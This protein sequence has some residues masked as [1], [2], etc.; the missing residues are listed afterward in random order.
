MLTNR[1]R[2]GAVLAGVVLALATLAG[3][4]RAA[5]AL[6]VTAK[7][8]R[9]YQERVTKRALMT[10]EIIT[11]ERHPKLAD[12]VFITL[13]GEVYEAR[14][15]DFRT[16]LEQEGDFERLKVATEG[17]LKSLGLDL[18]R[19]AERSEHLMTAIH[20]AQRDAALSYRL[21]VI[22]VDPAPP[23]GTTPK[24]P[25]TT[26]GTGTDP[27]TQVQY[28]YQPLL[29]NSRQNRLQRDWEDDLGKAAA[30][31]Q[32]IQARRAELLLALARQEASLE[33]VRARF[34][35]YAADPAGYLYEPYLVVEREAAL[36][37]DR[38][39][40]ARVRQHEV[41]LSRPSAKYGDWLEV[42]YQGDD[43]FASEKGL[44]DAMAG[45]LELAE[46]IIAAE[47]RVRVLEGQV[48]FGAH[49]AKQLDRLT[50]DLQFRAQT[51]GDYVV[52]TSFNVKPGESAYDVDTPNGAVVVLSRSRARN[53][54]R[55]WEKELAGLA[56]DRKKLEAEMSQL[57][58]T[59]VKL[60][61]EQ[62]QR[63]ERFAA[64]K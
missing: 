62:K 17:E 53:V 9:L 37:Q 60:R 4:A 14:R 43:Y 22:K 29:S 1:T 30:E 56:A 46:K 2:A 13:G 63:R 18:E 42:R 61:T 25:P 54:L 32:K 26:P 44:R 21:P 15:A 28:V 40:K 45:D 52:V 55:D 41:L 51:T 50:I 23:K 34:Q 19:L 24:P 16:L 20:V 57:R 59:A 27:T 31:G 33:R 38:L 7:E 48:A 6:M 39:T 58:D 47:D 5:D 10:G 64:A 36:Y 35:R 8:A 3:A 11:A 49:L 12:W